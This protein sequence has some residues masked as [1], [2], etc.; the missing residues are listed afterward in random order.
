MKNFNWILS[1]VLLGLF[2]AGCKKEDK[3]VLC[4]TWKMTSGKYVGP[5]F[6]TTLDETNRISYKILSQN[7]FA[8]VEMYHDNPDSQFFS[9]FGTYNFT[10]SSYTEHYEACNI[11]SKVGQS[12]KFKSK[13]ENGK[14]IIQLKNEGMELNE[15]WICVNRPGE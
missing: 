6:S 8:V 5:G 10:D 7:H 1:L 14:W 15:T 11:P 2:F 3:T 13:V 4:G 9:A 12:L